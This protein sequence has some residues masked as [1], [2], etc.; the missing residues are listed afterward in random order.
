MSICAWAEHGIVM[1][2]KMSEEGRD[3]WDKQA[4]IIWLFLV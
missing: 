1:G 3:K 2:A 4:F